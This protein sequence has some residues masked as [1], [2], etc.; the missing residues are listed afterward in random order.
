MLSRTHVAPFVRAGEDDGCRLEVAFLRDRDGRVTAFLERLCRLVRRLEGCPRSM[1][2]EALA[3]QER[4]I[5]DASRLAGVSKSLLDRCRFEPP[6]GAARAPEVRETVFR[7][8]GAHWPPTSGDR[9]VPYRLAAREL[10]VPEEEV[11]R[12]LFADRPD[13]RILARAPRGD[14]KRLLASYNLDL[15]RGV[16]LDAERVLVTAKGGWRRI[17]RAVKLARLMYRLERVEGSGAYRVELTGPAAAF[18]VRPRRYGARFARVIPALAQAPG[19]T[20]EAR[21]AWEGG[22]CDF[23]LDGRAPVAGSRGRGRPRH[24]SGFERS[25]AR[26]FAE[27]LGGKRDGWSLGRETTPVALGEELFLPDFTF[28]HADGREALVEIVGFW[29]EEYL[30]SKVRKVAAAGLENLVL[31]VYDALDAGARS[32]EKGSATERLDRAFPGRVLTFSRKPRIG[33][34]MEAVEGVATST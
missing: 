3:R 7:A 24:D 5:R 14:G 17:F 31:V 19:W 22:L 25:L 32:A 6:P 11:D 20:L 4:R 26:D 27:K 34:V 10:D 33:E 8:R 21:V 28:R 16:L 2:V 1:I 23:F 29:T 15:A 9:R 12:L 18:L 30:D 13:A